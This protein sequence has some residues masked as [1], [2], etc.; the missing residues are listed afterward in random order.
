MISYSMTNNLGN[1][2]KSKNYIFNPDEE[3]FET[4]LQKDGIKIERIISKGHCSPSGFWYDQEDYEWVVLL[5]GK[6][7]LKFEDNQE[8]TLNS[9]DYILIEPH[10]KHRVEWTTPDEESIWLAIFFK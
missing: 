8:I 7:I 10:R 1:I 3:F 9:G 6:A 2:F 4:I 5:K